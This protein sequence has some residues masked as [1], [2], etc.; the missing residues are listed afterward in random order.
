[1]TNQQPAYPIYRG[2]QKPLIFKSFRGKY[3]Y[4][5]LGSMLAGL[6]SAML[7]SSILN[8]VWG[9]GSMTVIL[10]IGLGYTAY[11]QQHGP[12]NRFS[13][14]LIMPTQPLRHDA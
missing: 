12:K 2:L 6:I 11:R 8:L 13:G 5:G 1:M 14:I 9:L 4:W 3:I 10:T 7:L